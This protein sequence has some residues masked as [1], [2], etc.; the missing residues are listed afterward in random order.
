M[1]QIAGRKLDC[2]VTGLSDLG[3]AEV[4]VAIA[5]QH[6]NVARGDRQAWLAGAGEIA[7]DD[8]ISGRWQRYGGGGL[9]GSVA[10]AEQDM[11]ETSATGHGEV[12]VAIVIEIRGGDG[13]R[14]T[15]GGVAYRGSE[16]IA[17]VQQDGD[18]P[19]RG[20]RHGYVGLAIVIE[21]GDDR[22]DRLGA[23]SELPRLK[24]CGWARLGERHGGESNNGHEA[25]ADD[26]AH[27]LPS[28]GTVGARIA[29][30]C[31]LL[32]KGL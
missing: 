31:G 22:G 2:A 13:L 19:G 27:R 28:L 5:W 10:V 24:E 21:I 7:R 4:A 15:A 25:H 16:T 8:R 26:M 1:V 9:K 17:I 12:G 32:R 18:G 20:I 29:L 14:L 6:Q 30:P 11:D 23:G 3:G